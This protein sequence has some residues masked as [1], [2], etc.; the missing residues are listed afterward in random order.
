[1]LEKLTTAKLR[2]LNIYLNLFIFII[3]SFIH[4]KKET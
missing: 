1:M 3:E 4:I 2:K